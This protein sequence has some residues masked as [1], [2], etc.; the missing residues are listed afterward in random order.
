MS[1]QASFDARTVYLNLQVIM[2]RVLILGPDYRTSLTT[3][4]YP[5]AA[6]FSLNLFFCF[7]FLFNFFFLSF[8]IAGRSDS[9]PLRL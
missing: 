5:P 1:R 3:S 8:S 7:F 4:P 6:S 2:R 9:R